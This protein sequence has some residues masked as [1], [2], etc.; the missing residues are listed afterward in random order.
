MS[1]TGNPD[2]VA[3]LAQTI[4][5]PAGSG[6]RYRLYEGGDAVVFNPGNLSDYRES[7]E[8]KVAADADVAAELASQAYYRQ[9]CGNQPDSIEETVAALPSMTE[10]LEAM[11]EE[12]TA[13]NTETLLVDLRD[14]PGGD[15]QFVFL[16]AYLL[17]GWEGVARAVEGVKV[18]KRRTK[19]YRQRYGD[20]GDGSAIDN[21]A[22]YDFSGFFP[23][24]DES[25]GPPPLVRQLL[26]RS[27]T[28]TEFVDQHDDGGLYTPEKVVVV[29]SAE[30]MSSAFACAAQLTALGADIVGV[31]SGQ[32]PISFGEHVERTLPHTGLKVTL[33]GSM[34]QW[35]T[36][37]AGDVLEPDSKLTPA[38]FEEYDHAR[39]AGLRLAFEH[40]G[41]GDSPPTV[42]E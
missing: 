8:A 30:T 24:T 1:V 27:Q 33:A 12:M 19:Q 7:L 20:S 9:V 42:V 15:S 28:A 25:D 35:V 18:V 31:P 32:A 22:D 26:A 29:V 39:D 13:A 21:P 5:H 17:G 3:R 2:P 40:A 4:R 14:N 37:P 6:P 16:L 41:Y 36:D 23:S 34:Y 11:A 10:T 38:R